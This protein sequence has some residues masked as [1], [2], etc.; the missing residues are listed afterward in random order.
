[1]LLEIY[2]GP[3]RTFMQRDIGPPLQRRFAK[4]RETIPAAL[5]ALEPA[6][7]VA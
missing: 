7:H 1:M 6:V 2:A 5:G 3:H 4:A